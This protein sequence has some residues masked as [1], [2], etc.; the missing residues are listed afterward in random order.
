[1]AGRFFVAA[2]YYSPPGNETRKGPAAAAAGIPRPNPPL[3]A[4]RPATTPPPLPS[5]PLSSP[6]LLGSAGPGRHLPPFLTYPLLLLCSLP[7]VERPG[8]YG[9]GEVYQGNKGEG[10]S[11]GGQVSLPSEPARGKPLAESVRPSG[12]VLVALSPGPLLVPLVHKDHSSSI[13][14]R[15]SKTCPERES[16]DTGGGDETPAGCVR[17]S[18]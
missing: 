16:P 4:Q 12:R 10:A 2:S 7:E 11:A 18:T 8:G 5:P 15:A 9:R 6:L 14:R 17:A 3:P 1:V 13:D